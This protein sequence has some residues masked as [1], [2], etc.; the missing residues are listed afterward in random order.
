VANY[1]TSVQYFYAGFLR[2]G[3]G[4]QKQVSNQASGKTAENLAA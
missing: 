1:Y 2:L 3:S 4:A